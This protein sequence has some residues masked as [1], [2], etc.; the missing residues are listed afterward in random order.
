[1][2]VPIQRLIGRLR[3]DRSKSYLFNGV[4]AWPLLFMSLVY[5]V[6]CTLTIKNK[7]HEVDQTYPPCC[8]L[9]LRLIDLPPFVADST[10]HY[11]L[12]PIVTSKDHVALRFPPLI[13]SL[14][15]PRLCQSDSEYMSF[16][17][18]R[19]PQDYLFSAHTFNPPD[20]EIAGI[21]E[22][23]KTAEHL[24]G[25]VYDI[26][27]GL[28]VKRSKRAS[29]TEA[30]AMDFVR[31][32]TSIPVPI[33]RMCFRH[34]DQTYIVMDRVKG[35]TLK[36]IALD[37]TSQDLRQ[38]AT[39]LAGYVRELRALDAGLT[40]AMGSWPCGPYDNLLFQP[41]PLQEFT[42]AEQ[43][44]EYWI[45]RLGMRTNLKS[46]PA[47]LC[48]T[49]LSHEVVLTHGDLAAWNIMV[50][51]SDITGILDW[52][53]FGWYPDFWELMMASRGS[54]NDRW[55]LELEA[56]L[57]QESEI[58]MNYRSVLGDIFFRQWAE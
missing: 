35:Q 11:H 22:S 33:V 15:A 31:R 14:D 45:W 9:T 30:L 58:S 29:V 16:A 19:S 6:V 37:M 27:G 10:R 38:V 32:C 54:C 39:R 25:P 17:R 4:F 48:S 26:G 23:L 20:H 1:M 8:S 52:E 49:G 36:S 56:A 3:D 2:W 50:Q 46:I 7:K 42:L 5:S 40:V 13:L 34:C 12:S 44:H 47:T 24:E 57:G 53:L 43:F 51:G 21:L 18:G 41:S 55:Q 28:V